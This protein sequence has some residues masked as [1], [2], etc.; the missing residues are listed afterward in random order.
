[1]MVP[2]ASICTVALAPLVMGEL[3]VKKAFDGVMSADGGPFAK[4]TPANT[5]APA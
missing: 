3:S 2:A 5:H 1:M 4:V